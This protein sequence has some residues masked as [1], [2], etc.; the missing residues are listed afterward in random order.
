MRKN[1]KGRGMAVLPFLIE[2]MSPVL[3]GVRRAL[4]QE[5]KPW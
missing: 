1:Q 4:L 3:R 5:E 2:K